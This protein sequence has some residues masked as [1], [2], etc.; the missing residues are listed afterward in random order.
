MWF[1]HK[2]CLFR[3]TECTKWLEPKPNNLISYEEVYRIIITI[4]VL[5]V[6]VCAL[7]FTTPTYIAQD[8]GII[9]QFTANTKSS[10]QLCVWSEAVHGFDVMLSQ[11]FMWK[12][13]VT[14]MIYLVNIK[15]QNYDY[16]GIYCCFMFHHSYNILRSGWMLLPNAKVS[17]ATNYSDFI[18]ILVCV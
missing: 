3:L 15:F 7:R 6:N 9:R 13:S 5:N 10:L 18:C 11:V 14:R 8:A 16:S 2:T 4:V 12:S 17:F 1:A